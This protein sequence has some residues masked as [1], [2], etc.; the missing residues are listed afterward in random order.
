MHD[1]CPR[2]AYLC[3]DFVISLLP[4]PLLNLAMSCAYT[5]SQIITVAAVVYYGEDSIVFALYVFSNCVFR[6]F[7]VAFAIQY[8][9]I[10]S[11][12]AFCCVE[13]KLEYSGWQVIQVFVC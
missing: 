5:S 4:L 9:N 3:T 6:L 11:F 8:P 2:L 1:I 13:L 7:R 10:L 12:I